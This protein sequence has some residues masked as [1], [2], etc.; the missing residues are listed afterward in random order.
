MAVEQSTNTVP[1]FQA[2]FLARLRGV[3]RFC[4]FT[5]R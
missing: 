1:F 4:R 3:L 5:N 2:H